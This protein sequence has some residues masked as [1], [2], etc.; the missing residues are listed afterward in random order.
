LRNAESDH[1][2][3]AQLAGEQ[4]V[5]RSEADLARAALDQARAQVNAARAQINQQVASTQTARLNMGRTVIRSP[6]DGVVL[7]RAVEPGQTVAASLQAPILFQI[8]E[9]LAKMEIVLAIDEADIGKVRVGQDVSFS[10]DAYPERQYRGKVQQLRLAA[11]NT[12]NVITYPVVVAVDNADQTLLPGLTANAEI[13]VSQRTDVLR[14]SSAAL[15]YKPADEA[16]STMGPGERRGAGL[17]ADLPRIAAG[18]ALQPP[19]QQAFDAA[20][21]QVRQRSKARERADGGNQTANP[22][23]GNR[24]GISGGAGA[25]GG[26]ASGAIRQRMTERFN[27]QFAAFRDTLSDAQRVRWDAELAA[28]L[29][30]RRA[31]VYK[32]ADG[33]IRP[34]TV[35]VGASD[36]SHTE[37]SGDVREGDTLVTGSERAKE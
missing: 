19:Q 4:L 30:A 8:A 9:D 34:V 12:N 3:K 5:A 15:R 10:V 24:R 28:L 14:V 20:L 21:E 13:E 22:L 32:L 29:G 27:Q 26:E 16:E 36:G 1:S 18:L 35:R 33:R 31:P 25:G 23:F 2:R 7:T 37:I 6:V 11:T 17:A